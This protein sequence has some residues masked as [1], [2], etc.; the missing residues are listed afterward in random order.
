MEPAIPTTAPYHERVGP[1]VLGPRFVEPRRALVKAM[2]WRAKRSH[3]GAFQI[4]PEHVLLS[5]LARL[6]RADHDAVA[7]CSTGFRAIMR[8]ERFIKARRA[9]G[10][11]EQGLVAILSDTSSLAL[12]SGRVW[13]CLAPMPPAMRLSY[14]HNDVATGGITVIGSE[15]FIAGGI[16]PSGRYSEVSVY[17]AVDD[18]WFALPQPPNFPHYTCAVTCAGRLFVGIG[19]C[20]KAGQVRDSK[21]PYFQFWDAD[22]QRWITIPSLPPSM[23]WPTSVLGGGASVVAAAVGSQIFFCPYEPWLTPNVWV[24]DIDTETW[25]LLDIP[26]GAQIPEQRTGPSLYV[27]GSLLHM[28]NHVNA[29]GGHYAYDTDTDEW[30]YVFGGLPRH[31]AMSESGRVLAVVNSNG[32]NDYVTFKGAGQSSGCVMAFRRSPIDGRWYGDGTHPID[33]PVRYD[34]VERVLSVAMP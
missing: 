5:C 7:D 32:R 15:I 26:E 2:A 30:V 34:A 4:L 25:R 19:K 18:E 31:T 28:L 6:P 21:E 29:T 12:V 20:M 24:F 13:R 1:D 8:S 3:L 9:E 11:T 16:R 14:E 23:A 22:S 17:D 27:E 33:L 10:C